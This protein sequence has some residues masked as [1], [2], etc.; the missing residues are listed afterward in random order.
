MK[1][2]RI[3]ISRARHN[4]R[5]RSAIVKELKAQAARA[6]QANA[7]LSLLSYRES[8]NLAE[9][10]LDASN[11]AQ[12]YDSLLAGTNLRPKLFPLICRRYINVLPRTGQTRKTRAMSLYRVK[13]RR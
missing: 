13:V 1:N 12:S 4:I 6:I 3:L 9:A 8:A 5:E 11:V 2:E 10:G 7:S